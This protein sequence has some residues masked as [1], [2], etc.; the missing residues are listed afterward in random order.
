M[1]QRNKKICFAAS[2]GGHFAQI[3][4]LKPLME[5]YPCFIV[6]E[7]LENNLKIDADAE[8]LYLRHV[9]RKEW[10]CIY[11]MLANTYISFKI[12]LKQKPDI[13][14]STGALAMIPLCILGK[15]MGKRLIF[16]ESFA[17]VQTKTMTGSVLYRFA[18]YF[19]VQWQEMLKIYPKGI[20]K[21]GIY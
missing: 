3:I 13:I 8:I 12:L 6:T 5:E 18:D 7:K 2:A 16:M 14:I 11:Y 21:G 17:K 9:N 4:R 1:E 15:L 20:Y 19:F 10:R